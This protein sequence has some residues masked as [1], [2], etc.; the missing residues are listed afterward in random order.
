MSDSPQDRIEPTEIDEL[1]IENPEF[2]VGDSL[3]YPHHGA[4]VVIKKEE[5]DILGEV[6]T[7][8]TIKILHNDMT[9]M[10]PCEK[11]GKSG[12]RHVADEETVKKV[13]AVLSADP[14]EMPT[15]WNRRFKQNRDKLESGNIYELAEVVRNLALR[16]QDKGLSTGE[17]QMHTRAKKNLASELM[18]ALEMGEEQAEAYLDKVLLRSSA[19]T[20]ALQKSGKDA[21]YT[22]ERTMDREEDKPPAG[23]PSDT[24]AGAHA[25]APDPAGAT[26]G[27][28]GPTAA[29]RAETVDQDEG[30]ERVWS[31][32]ARSE[33]L[34]RTIDEDLASLTLIGQRSARSDDLS[35]AVRRHVGAIEQRAETKSELARRLRARRAS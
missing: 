22:V 30:A 5:R 33:E 31:L 16:E 27:G 32:L 8:L 17:T 19:L 10:V 18:Y 21:E 3:V 26:A 2:E 20:Y 9:V 35:L 7:Y 4:G 11:A 28:A 14:S 25:G 23:G 24:S 1:E 12:L 15:N 34:G 6:R 13:L 29:P